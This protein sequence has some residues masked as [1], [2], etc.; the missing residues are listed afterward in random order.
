MKQFLVLFALAAVASAQVCDELINIFGKV[1]TPNRL[2]QCPLTSYLSEDAEEY[3]EDAAELGWYDDA[4]VNVDN[5]RFSAKQVQKSQ[6]QIQIYFLC[7]DF[8]PNRCS[9]LKNRICQT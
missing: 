6:I 8:L 3:L 1:F 2:F 4:G 9:P 5:V 7:F